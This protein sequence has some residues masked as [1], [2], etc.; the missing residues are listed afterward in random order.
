M[1][2][3]QEEVPRP[4]EMADSIVE[5]LLGPVLAQGLI[6]L[7]VSYNITA[8]THAKQIQAVEIP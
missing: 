7:D 2:N 6:P 1:G 8:S 5:R 3:R 4:R